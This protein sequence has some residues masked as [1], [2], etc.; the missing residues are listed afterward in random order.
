MN[1]V[2]MHD[3]QERIRKAR[4]SYS[5]KGLTESQFDIALGVAGIIDRHIHKN[6]SFREPLTDY[7][8]AFARSEKF[9]AV[10]GEIIVR[11]IYTARYGRTMNATREALRSNEKNLPEKARDEAL[12][13]ARRIEGL[14]CEGE[15]MPFYKAYDHEGRQLARSMMITE[16][17]A[18]QLMTESYLA[19]EG[20]ELYETG[21]ALEEKY[22]RPKVEAQ[23]EKREQ[24][25]AP[26]MTRS[27]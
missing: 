4:E 15:T 7:S 22:H 24:S 12:Q 3:A 19:A 1:D 18:K 21:K 2:L 13:A 25:R 11:D 8:H 20:R 6:G 27:Q 14:I 10:K 9:D 26:S 23:R 16:T 17:G 5:G